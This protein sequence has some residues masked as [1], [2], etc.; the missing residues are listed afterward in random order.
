MAKINSVLTFGDP[1]NP[2]P[3]TGAGDKTQ[4]ICHDDDAVCKGGFITVDHLTYAEDAATAAE[5]VLQKAS[6]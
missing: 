5:F 6:T 3:I 4:I 2:N 1:G